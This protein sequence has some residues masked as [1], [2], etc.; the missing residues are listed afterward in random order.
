MKIY[1]LALTL[2]LSS[3]AA[4]AGD[5]HDQIV[6]YSILDI[7]LSAQE[8]RLKLLSDDT[9][10]DIAK[11]IAILR[12]APLLDRNRFFGAS[13]LA[14]DLVDGKPTA[15]DF[16]M[17]GGLFGKTP[18]EIYSG[19]IVTG[20]RVDKRPAYAEIVASL[21]EQAEQDG[22]VIVAFRHR[23][24]HGVFGSQPDSVR[25]KDLY[26]ISDGR[27]LSAKEAGSVASSWWTKL[28]ARRST[29]T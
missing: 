23:T 27:V 4:H 25:W 26:F 12:S 16:I 10:A 28:C 3:F 7:R 11:R 13:R 6:N 14:I 15:F 1:W 22:Y 24:P 8:L 21:A 9:K 18:V 17:F 29:G 5:S 19:N 20:G 2:L